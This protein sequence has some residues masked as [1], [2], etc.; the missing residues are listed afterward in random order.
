MVSSNALSAQ[1]IKRENELDI[2]IKLYS[3]A[4]LHKIGL[5][6]FQIFGVL[7]N[8]AKVKVCAANLFKNSDD[9]FEAMHGQYRALA[10]LGGSV[11]SNMSACADEISTAISRNNAFNNEDVMAVLELSTDFCGSMKE[12]LVAVDS[13]FNCANPS[14]SDGEGKFSKGHLPDSDSRLVEVLKVVY[15]GIEQVGSALAAVQSTLTANP[16]VHGFK[17]TTHAGGKL[18]LYWPEG[19]QA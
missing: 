17:K 5:H 13:D 14:R 6:V 19:T 7:S 9:V 16:L 8:L 2:G 1:P 12:L 3:V 11:V 15:D 10:F 18:H 4:E